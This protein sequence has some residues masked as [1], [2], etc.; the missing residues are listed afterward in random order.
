M[1]RR[2]VRKR[3]PEAARKW[4]SFARYIASVMGIDRAE[5]LS[6][7]KLRAG[8]QA[9]SR[10]PS[11][12]QPARMVLDALDAAAEGRPFKPYSGRPE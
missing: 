7:E 1:K 9:V 6:D 8:V 12:R 10:G 5:K 2:A 3:D 11:R 4:R